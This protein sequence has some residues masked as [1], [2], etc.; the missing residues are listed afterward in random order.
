[1]TSPGP[2]Q[3]VEPK[4]KSSLQKDENHLLRQEQIQ[5]YKTTVLKEQRELRMKVRQGNNLEESPKKKK[6][7]SFDV[8]RGKDSREVKREGK[9]EE[10]G[11]RT[12]ENVTKINLEVEE[13]SSRRR[14][15][16]TLNIQLQQRQE[17]SQEQRQEQSQ[18]QSQEQS[19]Q[20]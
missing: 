4:R 16:R 17:Q 1:M 14:Q 2:D 11:E 3:E 15:P 8:S 9:K 19:Q 13:E 20:S 6:R 7:V 12:S 18:V 10:S 5:L